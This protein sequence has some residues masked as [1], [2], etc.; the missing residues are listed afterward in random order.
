MTNR[1][2]FT[3][4]FQFITTWNVSISLKKLFCFSQNRD[5]KPIMAMKCAVPSQKLQLQKLYGTSRIFLSS[6]PPLHFHT[7]PLATAFI[8]NGLES[9]IATGFPTK[10]G[11]FNAWIAVW[12]CNY[13]FT[14]ESSRQISCRLSSKARI[15]RH[16]SNLPTKQC[17]TKTLVS[18][19]ANHH[20][21]YLLH[22]FL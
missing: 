15:V 22:E 13:W 9:I 10:F 1:T 3:G 6:R 2:S 21:I 17:T 11:A 18:T 19:E 5:K 8:F 4:S 14:L 12:R 20:T 7:R 16:E